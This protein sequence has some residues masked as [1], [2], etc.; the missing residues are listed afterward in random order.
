[1]L[2]VPILKSID[3]KIHR[4]LLASNIPVVPTFL[5]TIILVPPRHFSIPVLYKEPAIF[6]VYIGGSHHLLLIWRCSEHHI[7]GIIEDFGFYRT[8]VPVL[9]S[10]KKSIIGDVASATPNACPFLMLVQS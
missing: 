8:H 6:H 1:M 10:D 4:T 5:L 9:S 7:D 3:L 2:T